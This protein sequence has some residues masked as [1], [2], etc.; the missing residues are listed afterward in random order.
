MTRGNKPP[1]LHRSRKELVV[2]GI[3]GG[4]GEYFDVDPI[5]FRLIFVVL[6]F[7]NGIGVLIYVL[8]W[9]TVPR[10]SEEADLD[11]LHIHTTIKEKMRDMESGF[12]GEEMPVTHTASKNKAFFAFALIAVGIIALVSNLF[13]INVIRFDVAWPAIIIIIGLYL[14]FREDN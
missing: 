12:K 8:L 14:I 11:A 4:L 2:A 10:E 3:S 6:T 5:I 9:I 7:V 13:S 1:K